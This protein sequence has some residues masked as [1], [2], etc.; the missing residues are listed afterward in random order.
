MRTF[1][2]AFAALVF[3]CCI[4]NPGRAQDTFPS[5]PVRLL[6]PFAAGTSDSVARIVGQK[7]SDL[8][9]QP[10]VIENKPGAN[11]ILASDFVARQKPDGY[12]IQ[13]CLNST[14]GLASLFTK[15]VP[16]DPFR[17][18]TMIG[19]M[20][21]SAF[22]LFVHSSVP[23][24]TMPEVLEFVKNNP[25][26]RSVGSGGVGSLPHIAVE[27]LNQSSKLGFQHVAYRGG[28]PAMNDLV[29]GHIP[30]LFATIGTAMEFVQAGRIKMIAVM[31]DK[32]LPGMPN[33][34]AIGETVPGFDL[35]DALVGLCGPADMP[36]PI[37]ARLNQALVDSLKAPDIA[38]QLQ[39][40]SMDPAIMSPQEF[41]SRMQKDFEVFKRVTAAAGIKPE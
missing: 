1:A 2:A 31:G 34:P 24:N 21:S 27:L 38:A 13:V 35:P 23:A 40:I 3:L 32:R 17:D 7:M 11:G 6:V 19:G 15:D 20:V 29:A 30:M 25:Q 9:G 37:V 18:F 5:K 22:A 33:L 16:F 10:V 41:R 39:K 36:A 12:T 4:E 14:H 26:K 8:L 28:G